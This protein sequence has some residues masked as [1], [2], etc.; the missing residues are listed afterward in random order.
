MR[1]RPRRRSWLAPAAALL[2][3]AAVWAAAGC[4][5]DDDDDNGGGAS[6][7]QT[8]VYAVGDAA[9]G[10]PRAQALADFIKGRPVDRFFYLGDVY[11]TG[12]ATEFTENYEPLFGSLAGQTDPV[13]GNHEYANRYEGYYP[14]WE[15]KRGWSTDQA[16]HRS[17]VDGPSGWQV[18]AYSSEADAGEEAQW[19]A[20][21]L[22]KHEGTCRI[23]FAHRGRYVVVDE[24]HSDNPDQQPVWDQLAGNVA[25]NLVG[26]NHI[27]GRLAPLEGVHVIVSGAG[28]HVIRSLGPQRHVVRA[29]EAGTPTVTELTL[30]R[31]AADL[32][33]LDAAGKIYD[34]TT[35]R[36]R[37]GDSP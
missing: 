14:Y 9:G 30:R 23:A 35:I 17:Y 12:T 13:A 5:D 18:L 34:D 15:T 4:G 32:R 24:E 19:L 31:G 10:E 22:A 20:G 2:A 7:D 28:G 11:E 27:Y 37:E 16:L 25:I 3:S 29:A 33:Q 26:H 36:C 1:R 8:V 6:S 21:E